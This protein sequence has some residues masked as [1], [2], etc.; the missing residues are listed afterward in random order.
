MHRVTFTASPLLRGGL[1]LSAV[2]RHGDFYFAYERRGWRGWFSWGGRAGTTAFFPQRIPH[3]RHLERSWNWFNPFTPE[4]DQRPTIPAASPELL[5][6]TV[7][8][9]WLFIA[10]SDKRWLYYKFSLPH[11]FIFSL[12]VGRMYFLNSGVK[13]LIAI[14]CVGD[15]K[16]VRLFILVTPRFWIFAF[17]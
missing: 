15:V 2:S 8:R 13:R 1:V 6:H 12:K 4:S 5:H 9:T 16:S 17:G 3:L 11:F 10:Y 7:W 14:A